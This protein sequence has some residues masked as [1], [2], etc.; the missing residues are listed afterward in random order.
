MRIS[1]V[2]LLLGLLLTVTVYGQAPSTGTNASAASSSSGPAPT[3]F[4]VKFKVKEG[5]NADFEKAFTEMMAGVRAHEPGNIYYD[6]YRS[7]QDPQTYVIIERYKDEAARLAH[8]KSDHGQKLI[9][10]LKD[11]LDG[12]PEAQGLVFIR[13]K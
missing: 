3:A 12:R 10:A 8:G 4:V 9:A 7:P 5:K 6:L 1:I 11:L 2:G 13:S